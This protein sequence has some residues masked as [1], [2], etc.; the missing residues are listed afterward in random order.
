MRGWE[1]RSASYSGCVQRASSSTSDM[2]MLRCG[3]SKETQDLYCSFKGMK[4]SVEC[5]LGDMTLLM[6][7]R[8]SE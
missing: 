8:L 7:V 6:Y 1:G 2:E 4:L 5:V 3:S